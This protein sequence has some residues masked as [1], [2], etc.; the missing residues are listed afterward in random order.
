[1]D[2]SLGGD[3]GRVRSPNQTILS[4]QGGT[5]SRRM[6]VCCEHLSQRVEVEA[7]SGGFEHVIVWGGETEFSKTASEVPAGKEAPL[8]PLNPR[9]LGRSM[10]KRGRGQVMVFSIIP[11]MAAAK[12]IS[13]GPFLSTKKDSV[14]FDK[15]GDGMGLFLRNTP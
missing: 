2:F 11:A 9:R 4:A 13:G 12:K 5:R 3:V 8:P 14:L 1:M 6:Q 7:C 15:R 10:Q